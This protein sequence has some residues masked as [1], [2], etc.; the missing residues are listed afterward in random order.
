[1]KF[2]RSAQNCRNRA[3]K[4]GITSQS[5]PQKKDGKTWENGLIHEDIHIIHKVFGG[6]LGR[7]S[8]KKERS[9]CKRMI[10][11]G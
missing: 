4:E 3:K 9:F 11:S 2:G 7:F 6:K 1:V 10:K 8:G 5:Y